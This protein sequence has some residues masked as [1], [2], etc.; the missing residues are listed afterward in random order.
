MSMPPEKEGYHR[1]HIIP[2][3]MGGG[4]DISNIEYLTPEEHALAH[5]KLYENHGFYEDAAAFNTLSSQWLDGR[6]I[7]GYKQSPEHI[8]RR[9]ASMDYGAISKKLKGRTSPTKGMKFAYVAKPKI[10]DA[11]RN[12]IK[13]DETKRRISDTLLGREPSNKIEYYCLHCHKRMPPSWAYKHG[14]GKKACKLIE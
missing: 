1:H 6:S 14:L 8:R 11:Q 13:S 10:G 2:K 3:H 12:K 4:D 9:I 7:S 5:L